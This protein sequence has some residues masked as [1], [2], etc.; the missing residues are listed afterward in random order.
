VT[1][2]LVAAALGC[3]P[4]AA[5]ATLPKRKHVTAAMIARRPWLQAALSPG[6]RAQ[7]LLAQM[8]LPEKVDLMTGNQGEAPFA[9]Y[10]APLPR[11]G[12]PPLKMADA[13]SGVAPRGWTLPETGQNA[14]ALPSM[15]ALGASWSRPLIS[16]YAGVVA[17]ETLE[18]GENVLLGPDSDVMRQPWWGRT[19]E[20]ESEEPLLNAD[21]VS[22]YTRAVQAKDVI[23]NLKHYTA[24]N[25]ETNRG[26]G[27]ND[28]I[29][30]RS[31]REVYTLPYAAAI[32]R[33]D[34]GSVMC[35]FNKINGTYSCE[36]PTTLRGLLKRT[37]G[38]TGFV[39]TDF[40]AIHDTVGALTG[41]TDMETG[42]TSVYDG[43]LL[44]A[45]ERGQVPES[46]VDEAC[47]RILTTMF[48][49]GI[50]DHAYVPSSIPV[51]A[52]DAVA[53]STEEQAI[54]LLKNS[55]GALPL[56]T[57][58]RSIVVA[59]ADAN[60]LAAPSGAP[61][62]SPTRTTAPLNGIVERAQAA[63]ASVSWVRGNDPVNAASMLEGR[64]MTTV[65]SSVL[66]PTNGV[67][68]GLQTFYWHNPNFQGSPDVIRVDKQINYDVGFLSTF[69]S[70]AGQ[71][72]QVPTPPVNQPVEQQSVVYDGH[73][74]A[75]RTGD[76]RLALTGFGDATLAIDGTEVATMTGADATRAYAA[77][78]VIH[79]VA[80]Q[81][82]TLHVTYRADHPF[83]SL[84]PG[85][86]L[87]EWQTPAGEVSPS[88]QRAAAAARRADA[89]I[90]YVRTYEGEQRDRV[91][92]HLP[93]SG[94]QLVR[95][96][97][98]ANPHTIVVLANSGPVTMPWL[99]RVEAV[100]QTYYGG[101]AQGAA[102][103]RVLWGDVNPSGKLTIT[104]P[105]GDEAVPAGV[106]NP[107]ATATD[108]DVAYGEGIN[109]GY[110]GYD[111]AGLTPLFPFGYGLSYTTFGYH[112]LRLETT[113]DPAR[114]SVHAR[115]R[116]SNDGAR[117]GSEVA[118]VYVGLPA[119]TGEP[120]KRLVGYA[121][122]RIPG[123][124]SAT[125]DVPINPNSATHPL[126]YFDTARDR[127]EI[128][129]GTYTV[130]VG[131]SERDTP[132]R[133]TFTVP[134]RRGL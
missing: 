43:A 69:G 93:Q 90:V 106:T 66:S 75:P 29:D 40:G 48:R 26:N 23:A 52:H 46:L 82:H 55:G 84:E 25:Q 127:W 51:G 67:G 42:T 97:A 54:T 28:V 19:D 83:D 74:T 81:S 71:T 115:F 101:Q 13:S 57:S 80:G 10:N 107:W 133:G 60:I 31:L 122:A 53:R 73:I 41:G 16:Q 125:V 134:R 87:L 119:S 49:L 17:D 89:A 33:A 64:N 45:V 35:S 121:K 79:W 92:L 104:Y 91:A 36:N 44:S 72:S 65:P 95:A 112:G 108:L 131:G 30:A 110:K 5:A 8:T 86:L 3:V 76:Y 47:L 63:G 109:V 61:W 37:L 99:S 34:P 124:G 88:I 123:H 118:E 2:A 58:A 11:L 98:A 1:A 100:V 117:A 14:T 38:F 111:R 130:Y 132:L 116:I 102:L 77:T 128:A 6:Q 85:T 20:T 22:A 129:P 68:T 62:V 39:L 96:V 56:K 59:G 32:R 24:Y 18:T 4:V 114:Q 27:V 113:P 78:P 9:Y 126:G 70:W 103:G 105:T 120:P 7:M 50:F 21:I 12:I 15:Q 94:D